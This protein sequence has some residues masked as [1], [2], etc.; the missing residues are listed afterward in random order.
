MTLVLHFRIRRSLDDLFDYETS[1]FK[2]ALDFRRL[3]KEEIHRDR[4]TPQFLFVSRSVAHVERKEKLPARLQH[5]SH[6][7]KNRGQKFIRNIDD[8]IEGDDP[9]ER[10]IG[11]VQGH[12]VALAED[13]VRV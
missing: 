10:F 5:S 13:D 1:C 9:G 2:A 12:H 8:G 6:L 4:M 3:E 11:K 7:A